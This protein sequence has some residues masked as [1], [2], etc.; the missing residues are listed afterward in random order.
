MVRHYSPRPG[1]ATP[2]TL[3]L[4]ASPCVSL[5]SPS[6]SQLF[7]FPLFLSFL[8]FL[9]LSTLSLP[10]FSSLPLPWLALSQLLPLPSAFPFPPFPLVASAACRHAPGPSAERSH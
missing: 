5:P 3:K 7:P 8:S 9:S 4:P 2:L 1:E 6:T 10:L